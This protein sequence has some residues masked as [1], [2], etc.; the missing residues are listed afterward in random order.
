MKKLDF[1]EIVEKL[2]KIERE[3][4]KE[5]SEDQMKD[6]KELA[7]EETL[8]KL[9][10]LFRADRLT[11]GMKRNWVGKSKG[12][13]KKWKE[14]KEK[15]KIIEKYARACKFQYLLSELFK[16]NQHFSTKEKQ[17]IYRKKVERSFPRGLI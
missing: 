7:V 10:P 11:I 14:Y 5:L 15:K 16:A 8:L 12:K 13:I 17:A 9:L 3:T 2:T 6:V 1:L 4:A